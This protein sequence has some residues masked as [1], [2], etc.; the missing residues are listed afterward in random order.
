MS[1]SLFSSI[2]Q[3]FSWLLSWKFSLVFS[4][5]FHCFQF[6]VRFRLLVEIINR[7]SLSQLDA[8]ILHLVRGKEIWNTQI[9]KY[10]I[11]K[12]RNI[13][14]TKISF[15]LPQLDVASF[16]SAIACES[17]GMPLADAALSEW[18]PY[19]SR[20]GGKLVRSLYWY[21]IYKYTKIQMHK[22]HK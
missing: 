22:K 18:G 17:I 10:E 20:W 16:Y 15:L 12:Y 4:Q 3:M 13:A 8:A 11:H 7:L 14:Q 6:P 9:Q 19:D 1:F 21:A 5:T 2:F